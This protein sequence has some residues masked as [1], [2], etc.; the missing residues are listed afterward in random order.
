MN[1]YDSIICSSLSSIDFK[2]MA[3]KVSAMKEE[4][5]RKH[6]LFLFIKKKPVKDQHISLKIQWS[7]RW[8]FIAEDNETCLFL[9]TRQKHQESPIIGEDKQDWW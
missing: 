5:G 9:F 7:V 8:N 2:I 6:L 3:I 1:R 4:A